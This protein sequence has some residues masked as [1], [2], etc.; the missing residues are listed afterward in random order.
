[1]D[2]Q[3]FN[4]QGGGSSENVPHMPV[5]EPAMGPEVPGGNKE[6]GGMGPVVGVI[7]IAA[8]L[9]L[10]GLYFWGASLDQAADELPL[11]PG[12]SME[13]TQPALS[14]SDEV[15]ALEAD[16]DAAAFVELDAQLEQDLRDL[17]SSF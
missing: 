3:P 1:M 8:L 2:Q 7:I 9:V 15:G 13:S 11:I 4:Q 5:A 14:T 6:Q 17:E 12:D 10:G 16:A